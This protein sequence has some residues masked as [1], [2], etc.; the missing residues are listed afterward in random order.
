MIKKIA[1]ALL[2]CAT[3]TAFAMSINEVNKASKDE[4]MKINGIGEKKADAI[5]KQRKKSSF[6]SFKDLE[7]VKGVGPALSKNIKNDVHKKT[8]KKSS[9]KSTTKK[10]DKKKSVK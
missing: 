10:S 5:I 4:L 8:P 7:A 9:K 1:I 2:V 6:K 3:T